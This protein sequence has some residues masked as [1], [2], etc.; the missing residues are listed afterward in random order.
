M[1]IVESE[2]S[3]WSRVE[4]Y[5]LD[6]VISEN[7]AAVGLKPMRATRQKGSMDRNHLGDY[8]MHI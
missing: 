8:E 2:T 6:T 4:T 7:V 5:I 1:G 3:I